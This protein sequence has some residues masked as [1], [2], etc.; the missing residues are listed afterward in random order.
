VMTSKPAIAGL[1][2]LIGIVIGIGIS[3]SLFYKWPAPAPMASAQM[4]KDHKKAKNAKK[5][6]AGH[7]SSLAHLAKS[8]AFESKIH[9]PRESDS[10]RCSRTV[11]DWDAETLRDDIGACSTRCTKP[12]SYMIRFL[13]SKLTASFPSVSTKL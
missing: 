7:E 11:K 4:P 8:I 2:L 13:T 9:A 6:K 12:R 10:V 3:A 1:A 5:A